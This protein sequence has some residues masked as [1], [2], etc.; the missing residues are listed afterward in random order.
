L[1]GR[2]VFG[3]LKT[4]PSTIDKE[5]ENALLLKKYR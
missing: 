3:G 4:I 2:I 5:K 1:F